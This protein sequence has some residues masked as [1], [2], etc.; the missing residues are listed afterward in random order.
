MDI[1]SKI[2][3]ACDADNVR[4]WRIGDRLRFAA[5]KGLPAH[6]ATLLKEHRAEVLSKLPD[7]FGWSR[8]AFKVLPAEAQR[9][10]A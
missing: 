10:V 6:L 8:G 2:F 5:A 4:I 3:L 9:M 1:V 7:G